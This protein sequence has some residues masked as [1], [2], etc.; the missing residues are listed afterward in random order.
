MGNEKVSITDNGNIWVKMPWRNT[1][2]ASGCAF[3]GGKLMTVAE[4]SKYL[5]MRELIEIIEQVNKNEQ[6][7]PCRKKA[8]FRKR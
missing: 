4:Y 1:R 7:K 6:V 3:N 5:K 2:T 8:N